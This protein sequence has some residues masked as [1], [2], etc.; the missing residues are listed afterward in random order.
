MKHIWTCL[1]LAVGCAGQATHEA[2]SV[3]S[4]KQ[5]AQCELSNYLDR[6]SFD[7]A[8]YGFKECLQG[9]DASCEI[10]SGSIEVKDL[11]EGV[12]T[13]RAVYKTSA[14]GKHSLRIYGRPTVGEGPAN[15][16]LTAVNL[17]ASASLADVLKDLFFPSE[18]ASSN[19][20]SAC[21]WK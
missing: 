15:T 8:G 5:L 14:N 18:D 6:D 10:K 9:N 1:F 21:E 17:P 3:A 13:I 2:S 7:V 4:R 12:G 19:S 16:V 11:D 20:I